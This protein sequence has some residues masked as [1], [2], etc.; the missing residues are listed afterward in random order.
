MLPPVVN[1][2]QGASVETLAG[3][4]DTVTLPPPEGQGQII[5]DPHAERDSVATATASQLFDA[6]HATPGILR[7]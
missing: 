5:G 3:G 2:S 6:V 1:A 4:S 7:R